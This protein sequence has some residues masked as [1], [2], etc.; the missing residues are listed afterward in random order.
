[1]NFTLRS[2]GFSHTSAKPV[3]GDPDLGPLANLPGIWRSCPGQ[4]WNIIALPCAGAPL[5][6]R[7]MVNQFDEELTFEFAEKNVPNRGLCYEGSPLPQD[8]FLNVLQYRQKTRQVSGADFPPSRPFVKDQPLHNETGMFLHQRNL[9]DQSTE[10]VRLA[11]IPHGNTLLALGHSQKLV[12]K[13]E[14]PKCSA[15]PEGLGTRDQSAYHQP[16]QHFIDHPVAGRFTPADVNATMRDFMSTID[17]RETQ[18]LSFDTGLKGSGI[19]TTPFLRA[20]AKP[21]RMQATYWLETLDEKEKT[22]HPILQLRYSQK[23][24]LA[25]FPRL[26]GHDGLIQWPHISVNTLRLART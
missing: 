22:G 8:Q 21:T 6:F 25:F 9:S 5:G 17:V 18:I 12:G 13:A 14:I 3:S 11:S 24:D 19:T 20:Q 7:L 2:Q 4:G 10:L 16:Y 1:M 23:V 26:D 15:L